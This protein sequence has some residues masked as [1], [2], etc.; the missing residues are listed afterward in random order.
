M[1][2]RD[3]LV[4]FL[5]AQRGAVVEIV[6]DLDEASMR[7]TP[8]ASG[9]SPAS[10]L[11]HLADA[12]HYWFSTVIGGATD[13]RGHACP[14]TAYRAQTTASNTAIANLPLGARTTG[15]VVSCLA[16]EVTTLRT[17]ILHMIEETARHAGHL[18]IAR[19]LI[20]GRTG[21]GPR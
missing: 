18:D 5:N 13:Q 8:A 1:T 2:E 4:H 9:W 6:A 11:R 7:R 17:V 19:E 15:P 21:L 3:D 20:D 10:L 16:A 12:E 14:V